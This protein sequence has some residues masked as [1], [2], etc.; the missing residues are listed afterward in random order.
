V[1]AGLSH[2]DVTLLVSIA[3]AAGVLLAALAVMVWV[4]GRQRDDEGRAQLAEML[5]EPEGDA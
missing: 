1:S 2:G 4:S 5:D 3:V